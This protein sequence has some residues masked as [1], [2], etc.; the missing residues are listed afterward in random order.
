MIAT[1][2]SFLGQSDRRRA[3]VCSRFRQARQLA[4]NNFS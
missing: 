4:I 3:A 2:T 1:V